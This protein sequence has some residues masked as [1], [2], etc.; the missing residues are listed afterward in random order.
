MIASIARLIALY[1]FTTT[2][3]IMY[4]AIFVSYQFICARE[5]LIGAC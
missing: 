3:D 2:K 1:I 5:S 4:N